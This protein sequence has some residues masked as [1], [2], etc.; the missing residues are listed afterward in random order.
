MHAP[1]TGWTRAHWESTVDTTLAAVRPYASP[2]H[3]LVALPGPLSVSG[4]RSD[5]LEGFARTF[6]AAGFR[7]AR[8]F[9]GDG[10]LAHWYAEGIDAGTDPASPE[11]WPRLADV[12]Q[13]RVEAASIAIALHESRAVLWDALDDRVRARVVDWLAEA[14]G[15]TDYPQCNWLWFQNVVEAFL[16]SVGGPWSSSDLER[17]IAATESWYRGDGWYT[18][19]HGRHFDWYAGW[20]MN[21][22]PLW[23]CRM[24]GPYVDEATWARYRERLRAY[25]DGV[26][27][28]YS[29]GGAPLHQGRSLTYRHAALAPVWA[30]AVF[31][32]T[33]LSPGRT[34]R[35]AN[36]VLRY[37]TGARL[38][39]DG[40]QPIGWR[41]AF[42]AIRQPYSGAGSPY[43]SGKAFAGLVLA[44]DHPVWT[45]AEEPLEVET[46]DV[47]MTLPAPGWIV[48]G[49]RA[50]GVVRVAN[51]G[52][53]GR[54]YP[55]DPGYARHA[56][57]THA[58]P[59]YDDEARESPVDSHVALVDAHGLASHRCPL[60]PLRIEGRVGVSRHRA[61]WVLG[62][63]PRDFRWPPAAP[64]FREGP[65]LTSASVLRGAVEVRLVR[66]GTGG[67]WTLRIGG[68]P[69]ASDDEPL[70]VSRGSAR[71]AD[72]LTS[73]V[74][75]LIGLP[76]ASV[77]RREGVNAYGRRSA[78]PIVAS[79][80]PVRAGAL[81]AA[82]VVLGTGDV[83]LPTVT[84]EGDAAVV[85][86]P[87]GETDAVNL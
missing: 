18:D 61:R 38:G 33:P 37:F 64:S 59:D 76:H 12:P 31:D 58:G 13:A 2:G 24:S 22:Y 7:L 70:T 35:L 44:P 60:R 21:F 25:L 9:P 23:Y 40:L 83:A 50:D 43:W 84:V 46:R 69:L 75:G 11:A 29:P 62:G 16:R 49:T 72:G 52:T 66:V 68:Y 34:R 41:G 30:G 17:N 19:G 56:Y 39:D 57:S 73:T 28:L 80:G 53:D 71:R 14:V 55:D 47:H 85:R 65:W 15:R 10:T 86:W 3:A 42:P 67:P 63:L 32:A 4:A 79:D 26:Q 1:S 51:H 27:H 87:D 45:D 81:F 74:E 36:G 48:S 82:A 77:V 6:L 78:T 8:E 54:Y 20:A 5:G